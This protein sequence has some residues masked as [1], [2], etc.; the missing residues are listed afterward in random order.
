DRPLE[1]DLPLEPGREIHLEH[2]LAG[3]G[4]DRGHRP[5]AVHVPA[6]QMTAEAVAEPERT[7][8]VDA[9][10]RGQPPEV[11]EPEGLAA[12]VEPGPVPV[13]GFDGEAAA[14]DGDAVP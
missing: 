9:V 14:V 7:L 6:D 1:H 2:R 10:P 12:G 13:E 4:D 8:D 3:L 5:R 11:R